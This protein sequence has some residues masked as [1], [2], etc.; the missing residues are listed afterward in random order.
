MATSCC[1]TNT[2]N[3]IYQILNSS[4]RTPHGSMHTKVATSYCTTSTAYIIYHFLNSRTRTP[5]GSMDTKVATSYCTITNQLLYITSQTSEFEPST[6]VWT[7]MWQTHTAQLIK[8]ILS[9]T[10]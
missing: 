10:Y 9:I 8:L 7:Q 4:I 1:T 2:T 5:H 6:E 3:I